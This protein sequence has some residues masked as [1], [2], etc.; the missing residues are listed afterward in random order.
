MDKE[1]ISLET[2]DSLQSET[3]GFDI[4]KYI[5]LP[6]VLGQEKDSI[7]YFAGRRLAR[8]FEINTLEDVIFLFDRFRWG[9]LE[10]IK[11]KK[12]E[13]R[14]HL[15]SDDVARRIELPLDVEFRLE[16]G[17][18]AEAVQRLMERPCEAVEEVNKRLYRVELR[19]VFTD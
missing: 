15:M 11:H 13:Q 4:L 5:C 10:I 8:Q 17:F 3:I 14:F 16:A 7:L 6:D 9:R 18:L 12:H 1:L 19:V 2:I